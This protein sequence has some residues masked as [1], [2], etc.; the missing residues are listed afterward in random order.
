MPS[1]KR[2]DAASPRTQRERSSDG[3][4]STSRRG[5]IM[6]CGNGVSILRYSPRNGSNGNGLREVFTFIGFD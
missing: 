1:C 2:S 3:A 6:E 5:V 4:C